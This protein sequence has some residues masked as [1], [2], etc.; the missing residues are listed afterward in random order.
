VWNGHAGLFGGGGGSFHAAPHSGQ[1]VQ[2]S[3]CGE[4]VSIG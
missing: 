2:P 3:G 1:T 4:V